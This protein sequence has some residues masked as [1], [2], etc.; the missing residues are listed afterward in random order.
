MN[1]DSEKSRDSR[2]HDVTITAGTR[3]AAATGATTMAVNS[4]HHQAVRDLG[5]GLRVTAVASDG[6]IEGIEVDDPDW[7]VLSVQWH[8]EDLT[9][10]ARTWDRGIFKAFAAE[11]AR[12]AGR[13]ARPTA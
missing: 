8:P 5:T 13:S 9:T 6:V 3:L 10:D 11:V 1:H 2:T 12:R 4:Y 7:W